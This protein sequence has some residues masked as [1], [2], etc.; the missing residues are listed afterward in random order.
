MNK[1]YSLKD[2]K[3]IDI[4]HKY[5]CSVKEKEK[6]IKSILSKISISDTILFVIGPEGGLSDKEEEMLVESGF[7]RITLGSNVLRTET[8]SSFILS[9]I[10]YEF[11]R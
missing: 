11:M 1:I 9:A 8:A 7:E 6:T 3:D 2:L 4:K 5:I 10:D